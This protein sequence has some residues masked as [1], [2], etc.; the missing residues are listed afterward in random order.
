M[1][2]KFLLI[3]CGH[4]TSSSP[5]NTPLPAP[6][7]GRVVTILLISVYFWNIRKETLTLD[8]IVNV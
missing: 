5:G 3:S 7:Q 1:Q 6:T 8:L 4:W 2:S